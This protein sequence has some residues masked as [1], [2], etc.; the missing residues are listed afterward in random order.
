MA[1][2]GSKLNKRVWRLFERAGFSTMP[3]SSNPAEHVIYLGSKKTRTVDLLAEDKELKVKI[4]GSNKS[5]GI[6][7][8]FT[9]HLH[10][11]QKL[12]ETL[13]ADTVLFVFTEKEISQDE[14]EFAKNQGMNI[15]GREE[16]EYYEA[17]VDTVNEYAKY[18]IIHSLGITTDEEKHIHNVL[19]LK[20]HQ[21]LRDSD[22]ELFCLARPQSFC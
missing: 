8:G 18:E 11:Y 20:L 14:R 10:G 2:K 15:W 6:P 13:K 7:E 4:I 12:Q 22:K 16:L 21:P 5:G 19:A 9:A 3:N 1:D 17:V